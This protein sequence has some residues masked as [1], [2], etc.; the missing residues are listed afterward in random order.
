MNQ[1]LHNLLGAAK[2]RCRPA[3][4]I[5]AMSAP[6]SALGAGDPVAGKQL[7]DTR[8]LGCHGNDTTRGT[9]GPDLKGIFGRVAATASGGVHSRALSESDIRWDEQSLRRFLAAPV[10]AVPGTTMPTGVPDPAQID[11]LIAYLRVLK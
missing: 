4:L 9:I 11:D 10:K 3:L 7:Y 1:R 8:C 2:L 5:A 6:L